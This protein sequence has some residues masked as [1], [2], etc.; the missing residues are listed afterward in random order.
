MVAASLLFFGAARVTAAD[1][2]LAAPTL[3]APSSPSNNAYPQWSFSG[4]VGATFECSFGQLNGQ[5]T[6]NACTSPQRFDLTVAG[7]G[8]Y[9]FGVRYHDS[10]KNTSAWAFSSYVLYRQASGTPPPMTIPGQPSLVSSPDTFS[11]D[12]TPTWTFTGEPSATFNCTLLQPF[13]GMWDGGPTGGDPP[14]DP[15]LVD[16]RQCSS[17]VYTFDLGAYPD[18][19]YTVSIT[20]TVANAT[21]PALVDSYTLDRIAYTPIFSST[22]YEVSSDPTPVWTFYAYGEVSPVL[23][24]CTL[25]RN[26][27]APVYTGP[28]SGDVHL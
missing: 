4:P 25:G 20:Q 2:V 18:H 11:N 16:T 6:K 23:I 21:S 15:V 8:A 17:G 13:E 7:D 1:T 3:T 27:S 10:N 24:T 9:S 22:P 5:M 26:G 19:G 28:G 14:P 12:S